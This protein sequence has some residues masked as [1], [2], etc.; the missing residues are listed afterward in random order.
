VIRDDGA[1]LNIDL[2]TLLI[3]ISDSSGVTAP[4]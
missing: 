4:G 3:K 2:G 1:V